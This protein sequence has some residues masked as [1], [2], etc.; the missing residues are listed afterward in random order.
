MRTDGE[1]LSQIFVKML[2][3]DK[4]IEI[5]FTSAKCLTYMCRTGAIWTDDNCI[6]LKALPCLVRMCSKGR[7]LEER[8][9]GM[10]IYRG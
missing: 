8:G 4:L 6:V 9:K 7:L 5:Q 3:R 2:Q 1:L 10:L